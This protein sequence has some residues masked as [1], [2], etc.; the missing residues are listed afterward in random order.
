MEPDTS[1]A[2][3]NK[4]DKP[5]RE[6]K[7]TV[8]PRVFDPEKHCGAPARSRNGEPCTKGQGWG[9]PEDQ[10]KINFARGNFRCRIHG[11]MSVGPKTPEGKKKVGEAAAAREF[12]HG[13]YRTTMTGD[14]AVNMDAATARTPQEL[15]EEGFYLTHAKLRPILEGN[16]V[17]KGMQKTVV[18][19]LDVLV[20]QEEISPEFAASIKAS[21]LGFDLDRVVG[22]MNKSGNL[23]VQSTSLGDLAN[24]RLR[25]KILEE[26][27]LGVGRMSQERP[28]REF[29]VHTASRLKAEAGIPEEQLQ[30]VIE[31]GLE[32]GEDEESEEEV[33][34][35]IDG[36]DEE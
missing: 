28:I 12:K 22:I 26:F 14:D 18:S 15:L 11:G 36:E 25:L 33:D 31:A 8:N 21:M 20:E 9:V 16:G 27:F 34:G 2:N 4:S 35:E 17:F 24:M 32:A 3:I 13:F 5:K 29:F 6:K 30:M 19:A 10:K 7:P 23:M 1:E